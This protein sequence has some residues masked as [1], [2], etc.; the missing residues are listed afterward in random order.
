MQYSL[1]AQ[2]FKVHSTLYKP[3]NDWPTWGPSIARYQARPTSP[4]LATFNKADKHVLVANYANGILVVPDFTQVTQHPSETSTENLTVISLDFNP[5]CDGEDLEI[6]VGFSAGPVL[7]FDP[8]KRKRGRLLWLNSGKPSNYSK[9]PVSLVRWVTLRSDEI[10][11]VFEDSTMWRLS[12]NYSN[13]D[14]KAISKLLSQLKEAGNISDFVVFTSADPN[15]NPVSVWKFQCE[16]ITDLRFVPTS[17]VNPRSQNMFALT[18]SAGEVKLYDFYRHTAIL[19]LQSYFAGLNALSWSLDGRYV[20][21]GG[22]D[23]CVSMWDVESPR[24]V[25]RGEGHN[26]WV[27]AIAF[28]YSVSAE[29]EHM[30]RFFSAGQDGHLLVWEI[31]PDSFP[32]YR[33]GSINSP[34]MESESPS[35]KREH[36]KV[37]AYP[38]RFE[39][40][41]LECLVD[42]AVGSEPLLGIAVEQNN[43]FTIDMSG[44]IQQWT[45]QPEPRAAERIPDSPTVATSEDQTQAEEVS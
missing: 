39:I 14:E 45:V 3:L 24:L 2:P 41:R 10:V 6:V 16:K 18:T 11:V 44:L 43:V 4:V 20:V 22:E 7:I 1:R 35:P 33:K 38:S 17:S 26:S 37:L 30:Y 27:S 12:K 21:A 36:V 25:F 15:S 29:N 8:L 13:E 31:T 19:T 32:M 40:P 28:D 5:T 9:R 42:V 34:L 23:D